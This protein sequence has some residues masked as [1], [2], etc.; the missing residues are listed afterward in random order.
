MA[1]LLDQFGR[2]IASRTAAAPAARR[3]GPVRPVRARYDVAQTTDENARHWALA[4][5][6]SADAANNPGVRRQ[7]RNR[8]RY[9]VAN[10][11]YA[12]G[13]TRTLANDVIGSGPRLQVNL[14]NK[15]LAKMIE[16]IWSTWAKKV[17]LAGKLWTLRMAQ[18]QDGE[19]FGVMTTNERIN[20]PVKLDLH[21]F[22]AELCTTPFLNPMADHR[23]DGIV[24][25]KYGRDPIQYHFLKRHPGDTFANMAGPLDYYT[26]DRRFVVHLFREE[27]PGQHRGIS[28]ILAALPLYA[29][30]RRYTLAVLRAAETVA[31]HSVIMQTNGVPTE[32]SDIAELEDD[33]L[34][35][36]DLEN[37][38]IVHLP[39]G[40]EAYQIKAEQPTTTYSDFKSSILCEIARCLNMPKNVALGDSSGY[41]YS[42]GRL[43][44]QVYF[45]AC[46]MDRVRI[47]EEVCDRLFEAFIEEACLV[48][49]LPMSV[50]QM[51][52]AGLLDHAWRWDPYEDIDPERTANARRMNLSQGMTSLDIEYA[53]EGMDADVE[54]Q[55]KADRLGITRGQLNQCLL[56][57]MFPA[58]ASLWTPQTAAPAAPAPVPTRAARK[59]PIKTKSPV[60]RKGRRATAV[61]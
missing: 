1:A 61:A 25:D 38:S 32:S 12:R 39:E 4:D 19:S 59:A 56:R 3:G 22:E 8:S 31:N 33:P 9:E 36:L 23:V 41:N 37:G 60:K 34:T 43:D 30:L 57:E 5:G 35:P 42:S 20:H 2:P 52:E 17:R 29:I 53:K 28:E 24:L 58:S 26:V 16:K 46:E 15:P 54:L 27:R 55:R 45:K 47:E 6:M 13:M 10:N 44:H 51:L 18:C 49:L 50:F 40:W 21:T 11:S 7:I 14:R 48:G